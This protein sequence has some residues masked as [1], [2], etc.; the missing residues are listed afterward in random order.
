[1][2]KYNAVSKKK[3]KF[4]SFFSHYP[5]TVGLSDTQFLWVVFFILLLKFTIHRCFNFYH[6]CYGSSNSSKNNKNKNKKKPNCTTLSLTFALTDNLQSVTH[7]QSNTKKP[8]WL[9]SSLILILV[10]RSFSSHRTKCVEY[11]HKIEQNGSKN[12][13]WHC[14]TNHLQKH[15]LG[16]AHVSRWRLILCETLP[17]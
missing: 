2:I 1:M 10:P 8:K 4:F 3:I 11:G 16:L 15:S 7:S 5:Q 12:H 9:L 17:L 13:R 14:T 6:N